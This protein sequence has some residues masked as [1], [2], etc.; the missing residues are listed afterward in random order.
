MVVHAARVPAAIAASTSVTCRTSSSVKGRA[1]A[2]K[3][4]SEP[5]HRPSL[6]SAARR[7]SV[8]PAGR[9]ISSQSGLRAR[10]P[11]VAAFTVPT[12]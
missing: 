7:S 6:T 10:S 2:R 12:R 1:A 5:Q 8:I 11:P 3:R 4:L 9:M